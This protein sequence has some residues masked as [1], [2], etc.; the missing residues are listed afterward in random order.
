MGR[1]GEGEMGRWGDGERG[2]WGDG[3]HFSLHTSHSTL[4]TPHFTLPKLLNSFFK[5][6]IW[7]GFLDDLS[8]IYKCDRQAS[9]FER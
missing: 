2:R 3:E 4:H 8:I 9:A 5:L 7:I 6:T 1:W